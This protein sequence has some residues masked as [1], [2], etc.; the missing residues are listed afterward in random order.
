MLIQ[1]CESDDSDGLD[2]AQVLFGN[3]TSLLNDIIHKTY[4]ASVSQFY[5]QSE[6]PQ[7]RG[8]LFAKMKNLNKPNLLTQVKNTQWDF[9][10]KI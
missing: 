4:D 7:N 10:H 8:A 6:E 2:E 1:K 3:N 9:I 5:S